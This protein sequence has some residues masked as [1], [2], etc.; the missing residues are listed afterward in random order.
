MSN[1]AT[2]TK[3]MGAAQRVMATGVL[4]AMRAVSIRWV[5]Q[6]A[7]SASVRRIGGDAEPG[8]P[9]EAAEAVVETPSTGKGS[10]TVEVY[11]GFGGALRIHL[12]R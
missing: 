6:R 8:S 5:V 12:I 2:S 10:G 4:A 11:D 1:M 3:A 7:R 9:K